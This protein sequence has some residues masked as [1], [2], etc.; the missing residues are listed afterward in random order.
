MGNHSTDI[1]RELV[2]EGLYKYALDLTLH[3][4]AHFPKLHPCYKL[5]YI[6]DESKGI[7]LWGKSTLKTTN[8]R[9]FFTASKI[10]QRGINAV[11]SGY[12]P[13]P[14]D[15]QTTQSLTHSFGNPIQ[16][17]LSRHSSR[18]Q[19]KTGYLSSDNPTQ[20][21]EFRLR[22][23]QTAAFVLAVVSGRLESPQAAQA[24]QSSL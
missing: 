2:S 15:R 19:N 1:F 3:S 14:H 22:G 11:L 16:R 9:I 10:I 5:S 4:K 8:P 13:I 7:I 17:A 12:S 20:T 23:P 24:P 21:V 18:K 6:K